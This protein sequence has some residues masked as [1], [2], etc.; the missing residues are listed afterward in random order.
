MLSDKVSTSVE[1]KIIADAI[2]QIKAGTA[3]C[4][5]IRDAQ[6]I[7]MENG[8][9]V[10][11]ALRLYDAGKLNDSTVVDKVIGRAAAMIMTA[12][13]INGCHTITISKGAL[14]WFLRNNIPV[15]Y[16]QCVEYI[17]NR[18]GDGKCPME[19]TV[20]GIEEDTKAVLAIREK[21]KELTGKK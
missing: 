18:T 8:R 2:T 15:T 9:G 20:L 12:G 11:P 19:Q 1:N 16:E 14:D 3:A 6:I 13:G 10:A 17:V 4:I 7:G 5:A 21:L